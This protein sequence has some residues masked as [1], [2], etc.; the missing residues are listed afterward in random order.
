MV[1]TVSCERL[2][3]EIKHIFFFSQKYAWTSGHFVMYM[4]SFLST[5]AISKFFVDI[6]C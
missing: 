1:L 6:I 3:A 4:F 2:R 5:S